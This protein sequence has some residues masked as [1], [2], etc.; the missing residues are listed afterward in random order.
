M[1]HRVTSLR[2]GI[3]HLAFFAGMIA[4]GAAYRAGGWPYLLSWL[5]LVIVAVSTSHHVFD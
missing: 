2:E 4:A 1:S 3:R 5:A